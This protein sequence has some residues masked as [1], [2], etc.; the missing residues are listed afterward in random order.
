MLEDFSRQAVIQAME[1]NLCG[2]GIRWADLLQTELHEEPEITWFV[3]GLPFEL[4]N[5]IIHAQV[6]AEES[7]DKIDAIL[8][9]LANYQIPMAC[10]VTP[11]MQAIDFEQHLHAHGWELDDTAP[12]MAVDLQKLDDH[13]PTP[14]GLTVKEVID[15]AILIQWM[16]VMTAGSEMPESVFNLLLD[17]YAQHGFIRNSSIRFY[18]GSLNGEP[19]ASSLLFLHGGVAGIYNVAT[20]PHARRQGIGAAVTLAALLDAREA[21]YRIGV[22]QSTQM[23]LHVYHT[24]G[25]REYCQFKLYFYSHENVVTAI[26]AS[27]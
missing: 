11:S 4:C 3:T 24:L 1:E 7:Q 19:V 26:S 21:G 25:F 23:G 17:L 14:V 13:I 20:L 12:G 8:K 5:G 15:G 10:M 6:V 16:R 18:L 9:Q 2:T 22:L 27:S